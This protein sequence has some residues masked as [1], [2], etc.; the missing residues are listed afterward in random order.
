MKAL[1]CLLCSD[2]RAPNPDKSPVICRCGNCGTRWEDPQRGRLKVWARNKSLV[3]V[4]GM[5]NDF[6]MAATDEGE[7]GRGWGPSSS[8]KVRKIDDYWKSVHEEVT[9]APGYLFDKSKRACW[10]CIVRVGETSD[11]SWEDAP[12]ENA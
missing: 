12:D 6:L 3:R 1:L 11:I 5:H 9:D 2:I 10:A 8:G 7:A 4:I